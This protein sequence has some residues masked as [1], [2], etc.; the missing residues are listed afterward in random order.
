MKDEVSRLELLIQRVKIKN[1]RVVYFSPILLSEQ[2]QA[3]N[4][5]IANR[6]SSTSPCGPEIMSCLGL[7]HEK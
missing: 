6:I 1:S 7:E 5:K 2:E 4:I 3:S